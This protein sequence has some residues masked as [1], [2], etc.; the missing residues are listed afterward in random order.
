MYKQLFLN[1]ERKREQLI[2]DVVKMLAQIDKEKDPN[3]HEKAAELKEVMKEKYGR[4]KP[5]GSENSS[6]VH[7]L[8]RE[9]DSL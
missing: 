6:R 2:K 9:I 4:V 1:S 3:A 7:K 5:A 8:E